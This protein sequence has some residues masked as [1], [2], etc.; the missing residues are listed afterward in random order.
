VAALSGT[1][2]LLTYQ[3][4]LFANDLW[5]KG[6]FNVITLTHGN[7][8]IGKIDSAALTSRFPIGG[9]WRLG[10]R[11]SVDRLNDV[12]TG[13]TETTYIP[14]A[15]LDWERGRWLFQLDTGAELG[16]REAFLQLPNGSFVQTQNTTRY[17]ISLSY[18]VMFQ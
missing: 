9:S 17:Y 2:L 15:L 11:F 10:P 16:S 8:E 14:S 6:D 7:T 13:S 3:T 1:G 4:Q 12:A 5:R 18:R